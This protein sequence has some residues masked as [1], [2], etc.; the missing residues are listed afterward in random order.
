[1]KKWVCSI[2]GIVCEGDHAP[3]VCP[4]CNVGSEYFSEVKSGEK[5]V[6]NVEK[7][8]KKLTG[9]VWR[10][11]VCDEVFPYDECPDTCPVCGVGKDLFEVTEIQ[12]STEE[13]A[14]GK[15][16][17]ILIIGSGVSAVSAADGA[18]GKNSSAEIE[19]IGEE[20][21][22]PYYR[23]K[24]TEYLCEDM[25]M[26]RLKIKKDSWYEEKNIKLTKGVRVTS[27]DNENKKVVLSN[28]EVKEFDKLI[29]ATGAKCFVP[30]IK[31][32]NVAGVFVIRNM[33]DT[34]KVK[35][36]AKNCK[37]AVVIGGGVLGLEAAWGLKLLGI[38]T[39]VIEMMQRILP[40]QLDEQGSEI[41]E[42]AIEQA[43]VKFFKGVVVSAIEGEK[44]VT[45]IALEN[46]QHILA[47]L[48]IISAGIA[49]NKELAQNLG[50]NVG[51]GIV[52]NEKMETSMKD[53]YACGDVAEYNG[54]I[55]GLW[56]VAMEQGKT[57]GINACGG[58]AQY[59]EQIQPLNFDGMNIKLISIGTIGNHD[60]CEEFVQEIDTTK[61]MYKKLYF[62]NNKLKGAILIGDV[63]KGITLI[64]GVREN[65]DKNTI[66]RKLYI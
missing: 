59:K 46:G 22:D 11:T 12:E 24:L 19:I 63:S 55:I 64:K 1:M 51:R 33:E 20:Q 6:E 28:G 27:I 40:K 62:E 47:D 53:V 7:E 21:A 14:E 44:K 5:K 45:S 52:V 31:N 13:V 34:E 23:T 3:E 61:K 37:R 29:L 4:I 38:E 9:K 16:E 30:P 15:D 54:K 17:K 25:Q 60:N 42:A 10:C 56:Q 26:D 43:G 8:E 57:A 35:E 18:R 48:V 58:E 49:P 66:M 36:Y 50:L 2:C 32:S 39:S 41:L 65:D